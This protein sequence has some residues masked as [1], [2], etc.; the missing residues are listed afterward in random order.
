[1]IETKIA[2]DKDLKQILNHLLNHY[3]EYYLALAASNNLLYFLTP[4]LNSL[5]K[6]SLNEVLTMIAQDYQ[7]FDD[8]TNENLN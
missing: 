6:Y 4:Y 5:E 1:M 2:Y 7:T 3:T 8:I